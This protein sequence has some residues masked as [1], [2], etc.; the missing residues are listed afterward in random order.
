M[1]VTGTSLCLIDCFKGVM[2]RSR[3]F[4][5]VSQGNKFSMCA[6]DLTGVMLGKPVMAPQIKSRHELETVNM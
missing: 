1:T 2:F 5:S 4:G 3:D 6:V